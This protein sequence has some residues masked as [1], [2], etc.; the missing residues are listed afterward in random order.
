[1]PADRRAW[2]QLWDAY[3]IFYEATL[4]PEHSDLLWGRICD[5][6]DPIEC[7]LAELNGQPIGV[8]HFFPHPDTWHDQPVCYLQDLY[9][10]MEHRGEGVGE[11]LIKSVE[12]RSREE[13]WALVYWQTAEDNDRARRLY[14]KLAGGPT[15]FVIYE[16]EQS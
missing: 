12:G 13:G 14:D 11:S 2:Q 7:L 10:D 1:M 3:L 5:P 8:V 9:V 15:R 4:P 6:E 16:M